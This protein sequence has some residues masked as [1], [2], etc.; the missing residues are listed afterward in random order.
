[1]INQW[2]DKNEE[3]VN[4]CKGGKHTHGHF[5]V[6]NGTAL[7]WAAYYGQTRIAKLLI[8]K[9]AGMPNGKC[10]NVQVHHYYVKLC[11]YFIK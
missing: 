11:E 5:R 7:H 1:M 9:G 4:K 10:K 2:L 6:A 8:Q 3:N